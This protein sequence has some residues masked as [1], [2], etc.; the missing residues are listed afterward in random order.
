MLKLDS[1]DL[2][3]SP[4]PQKK[5]KTRRRLNPCLKQGSAA[6][7]ESSA[8]KTYANKGTLWKEKMAHC[9][10]EPATFRSK[11]LRYSN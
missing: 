10:I 11:S 7:C 4:P 9:G 1:D 2:Y 3:N 6:D 5:R 8:V